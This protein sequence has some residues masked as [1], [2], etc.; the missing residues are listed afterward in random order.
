MHVEVPRRPERKIK[1]WFLVPVGVDFAAAR[2]RALASP[3][4]EQ[5]DIMVCVCVCVCVCVTGLREQSGI[6]VCVCVRAC[7]CV[8]R[9]RTG[10]GIAPGNVVDM[11]TSICVRWCGVGWCML[12]RA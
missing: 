12:K 4:D 1:S 6:G 8:T 3:A 7:A 11:C 9:P 2:E 5:R 10:T